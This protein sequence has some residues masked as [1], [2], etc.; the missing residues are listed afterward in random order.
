MNSTVIQTVG[1]KHHDGFS[2]SIVGEQSASPRAHTN[3]LNSLT[4]KAAH[5]SVS[6]PPA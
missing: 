5:E 6:G 2:V 3:Q 4:G 1:G